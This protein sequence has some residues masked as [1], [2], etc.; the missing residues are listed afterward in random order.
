MSRMNIGERPEPIIYRSEVMRIVVQQVERF[1][2]RDTPVL[3]VGET[4]TGKEVIAREIHRRSSR[5]REALEICSCPRGASDMIANELFGHERGAYT[6]AKQLVKGKIERAHRGTFVLDD[7]DD[8][9]LDVQGKL[10]RVLDNKEI[11]RIGAE[12]TIKVDIR[13]VAAAKC[14]LEQMVADGH[15]RADLFYRLSVHRIYLPPLR[16]RIEDVPIL[17]RHFAGNPEITIPSHVMKAMEDYS[18]PGN[19]RELRNAI[20]R[21]VANAEGNVLKLEDLVPSP[22][23]PLPISPGQEY[24]VGKTAPST[25][26]LT[27]FVNELNSI[28][29]DTVPD[30]F[31][32]CVRTAALN[33]LGLPCTSAKQEFR[34]ARCIARWIQRGLKNE[35]RARKVFEKLNPATLAWLLEINSGRRRDVHPASTKPSILAPFLGPET[36]ELASADRLTPPSHPLTLSAD[37]VSILLPMT[38][39]HLFG[40]ERNVR[41]LDQAWDDPNTH[42]IVLTAFGGVGKSTLLTHW[43]QSMTGTSDRGADRV[44]ARSFYNQSSDDRIL[45]GDVLIADALNWFGDEDPRGG[46]PGERGERLAQILKSQRTLLVLDGLEVVQF[47]P[48]SQEG[49][50][51]DE[52]L[53]VLLRELA[54]SS[55]GLCVISTRLRVADLAD[56]QNSTVKNVELDNLSRDAGAQLLAAL[57]VRGQHEELAQVSEAFDGHPLALAMLGTYLRKAYNGDVKRVSEVKLLEADAKQGGHA[58]RVM[59]SYS[60]WLGE[61]PEHA[62]LRMMGLFDRPADGPSIAVLQAEPAIPGLADAS[63]R[64]SGADWEITI[65]NLRDATLLAGR[66]A[67]QAATLEAHPL[68]REYFGSH[69]RQLYPE[70]WRE[71]HRRLYEYLKTRTKEYP[72]T[73]PEMGPLF[74]AVAHGC[75]AGLHEQVLNEVYRSRLMRGETRYA[76]SKLAAFGPIL[77][78]LSHFFEHDDW[79]LP[80]H[81]LSRSARMYVL[82]E[83]ALHLSITKGFPAPEAKLAYELAKREAEKAE[84]IPDLFLALRGLW[85]CH[86]VAAEYAEA[87]EAASRLIEWSVQ[88]QHSLHVAEA[89]FARGATAF[90]LGEL[91]VARYHLERAIAAYGAD[92]PHSGMGGFDVRVA[93]LSYASWALWYLGNARGAYKLCNEALVRARSLSDY[94]TIALALHFSAYLAQCRG[95]GPAVQIYA[96]ELF[97]LSSRYGFVHWF[98]CGTIMRGCAS[99]LQGLPTHGIDQIR[100]GLEVWRSA[101]AKLGLTDFV[102]KLAHAYKRAYEQADHRDKPRLL[103]DALA[104]VE[105]GLRI[106]SAHNEKYYTPELNRIKGEIIILAADRQTNKGDSIGASEHLFRLAGE[107]ARSQNNKFLELR[108]AKSLGR[109]MILQGRATEAKELLSHFTDYLGEDSDATDYVQVKDLL[110]K[111]SRC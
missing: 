76:S 90:Y 95:D 106:A 104:L 33:V 85:R 39:P 80:V 38:G 58:F 57:G 50:L 1:A 42:I 2:K 79:T 105:E 11:E 70:G 13:I 62:V 96:D 8:L 17:A 48:G 108:A 35:P 59:D 18:W 46:Y 52:G 41:V 74:A 21:A 47:P 100:S 31:F 107:I 60:K 3:I 84:S 83:A 25:Q 37:S 43:L 93:S 12:K 88:T 77:S 15:F 75:E 16:H 24:H 64:F 23:R 19:V 89:N 97:E 78:A 92:E 71:G 65:S 91:D 27:S 20:M 7:I 94:H 29:G 87:S 63:E 55:P 68:V 32:S 40:R 82:N 26:Q 44:Y 53:R 69:F 86:H 111:I 4:G 54:A 5:T 10:L 98:A 103:K 67:D 9:P 102:G 56:F 109:L 66:K 99:V 101:S 30:D 51:R 36:L 22:K 110:N 28:V 49:K 45:T 6:D 14:D 72:E 34:D 61:G 81:T 73:I